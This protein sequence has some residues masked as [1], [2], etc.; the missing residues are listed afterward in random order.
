MKLRSRNSGEK[1]GRRVLTVHQHHHLVFLYLGH[2]HRSPV[3]C[4]TGRGSK[5]NS[6]CFCLP[7]LGTLS[8]PKLNPAHHS[9]PDGSSISPAVCIHLSPLAPAAIPFPVTPVTSQ[10]KHSPAAQPTPS[11][12]PRPQRACPTHLCSSRPASRRA[13]RSARCGRAP[14]SPAAPG[15]RRCRRRAARSPARSE[16]RTLEGAS[17]AGTAPAAGRTGRGGLRVVGRGLRGEGPGRRAC[18]ELPKY[19]SWALGF[20]GWHLE[21]SG[22]KAPEA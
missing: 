13:R 15:S 21:T 8:I 20:G 17:V 4:L 1:T 6:P 10:A 18:R 16:A 12:Q 2:L 14:S 19:I 3:L 5:T 7:P 11:Q 9:G 22:A